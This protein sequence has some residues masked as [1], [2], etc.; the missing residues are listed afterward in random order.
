MVGTLPLYA[1]VGVEVS[2]NVIWAQICFMCLSVCLFQEKHQ[3]YKLHM[4]VISSHKLKAS[5]RYNLHL[6]SFLLLQFKSLSEKYWLDCILGFLV[7]DFSALVCI[8]FGLCT[9]CIKIYVGSSHQNDCFLYLSIIRDE[10]SQFIIFN[11]YGYYVFS[12]V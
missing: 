8:D 2:T 6:A 4:L 1:V 11:F 3:Y 9:N 12:G 7:F 10:L 5:R